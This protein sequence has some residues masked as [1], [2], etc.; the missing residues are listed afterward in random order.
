MV[1]ALTPG[2]AALAE[3]AAAKPA[4][5]WPPAEFLGRWTGEGRLGFAEGKFET[6]K[7]RVT[8]FA[9]EAA[10]LKQ[11]VRCATAGANIDV[12]SAISNGGGKLSGAWEETVYNIKGDISGQQ[13]AKGFRVQVKSD[14]L[15]ANMDL[16]LNGNAQLIEI[17]FFNSTLMGLTMSLIKD[18]P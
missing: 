18:Q 15:S 14:A 11:N 4:A 2:N 8:Y 12:K 5:A 1:F 7:C 17:Q 6:V 10:T 3:T 9:G 13:T 16:I